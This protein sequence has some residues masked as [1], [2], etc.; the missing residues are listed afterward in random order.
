MRNTSAVTE[1]V[2]PSHEAG[3]CEV[4]YASGVTLTMAAA[5]YAALRTALRAR[6]PDF[7]GHDEYGAPALVRL[8]DAIG[9]RLVT[10]A[11]LAAEAEEARGHDLGLW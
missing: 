4:V 3:Y 7:E 11:V 9:L 8:D 6:H 2:E 10:P 1:S 5:H